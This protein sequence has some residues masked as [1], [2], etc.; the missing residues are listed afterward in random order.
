M[1]SS[2][3]STPKA[4][5]CV[6]RPP[7]TS[8]AS[9]PSTRRLLP[10]V[11]SDN[12]E[13]ELSELD[14]ASRCRER[15]LEGAELRARPVVSHEICER[16]RGRKGL[17]RSGRRAGGVDVGCARSTASVAS[18]PPTAGDVAETATVIDTLQHYPEKCRMESRTII[19]IGLWNG[20]IT[21][22]SSQE[23]EEERTVARPSTMRHRL[24]HVASMT[25]RL[26]SARKV[27]NGDYQ[28]PK[29]VYTS[30]QFYRIPLFL[31][32][33][34][35]GRGGEGEL[36]PIGSQV[37]EEDIVVG[38]DDIRT[39]DGQQGQKRTASDAG[40]GRHGTSWDLSTGKC[41]VTCAGVQGRA[42]GKSRI[43]LGDV[44]QAG[45]PMRRPADEYQV[46]QE[47]SL[48]MAAPG[49]AK[50]LKRRRRATKGERRRI[51][52]KSELLLPNRSGSPSKDPDP[53]RPQPSRNNVPNKAPLVVS[54]KPRCD[55]SMVVDVVKPW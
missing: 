41:R 54:T 27:G 33:M 30:R 34:V 35:V 17:S 22:E 55:H 50:R 1:I 5:P 4:L 53:G 37:E 46:I 16:A 23:A 3:R 14:D 29:G 2:L 7:S 42:Y 39:P 10:K 28:Y 44:L 21:L 24:V 15:S 20:F 47:Q 19:I 36:S 8:P 9:T 48:Y 32:K 6:I 25:E 11:F 12:A 31:T 49:E 52:L 38:V 51:D 13:V 45:S 18:P 40:H 26:S 43:I